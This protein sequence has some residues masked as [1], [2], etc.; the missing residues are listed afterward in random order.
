MLLWQSGWR[1]LAWLRLKDGLDEAIFNAD[2][3][4]ITVILSDKPKKNMFLCFYF[5]TNT[6]IYRSVGML[7]AW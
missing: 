7:M 5:I 4:L 2:F 3:A 1:P 6:F